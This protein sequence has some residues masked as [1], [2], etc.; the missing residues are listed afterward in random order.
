MVA[1]KVDGVRSALVFDKARAPIQSREHEDVNVIS[2]TGRYFARKKALEIIQAFLE[3]HFSEEE[4]HV[5]R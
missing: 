3:T 2:L 1:N 4:R 5:R